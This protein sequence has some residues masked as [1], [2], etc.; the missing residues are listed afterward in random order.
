MNGLTV[1]KGGGIARETAFAFAAANARRLVLIGRTESTLAQTRDYV[2][3]SNNSVE[4]SIS[5]AD[6][7]DEKAIRQIAAET[8]TWDVLILNAGHIPKPAAV[9][10]ANISDYWQ[11]YEVS[12]RESLFALRRNVSLSLYSR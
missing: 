3:A 9:V 10:A 5:C 12:L 7:C 1:Q 6:V 11:A 2:Q 8:G 4:C